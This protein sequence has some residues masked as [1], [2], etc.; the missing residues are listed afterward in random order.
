MLCN[1]GGSARAMALAIVF[2]GDLNLLP[3]ESMVPVKVCVFGGDDRMLEIE[4]DLAER[5]E[6]V[7]FAIGL[8]LIPGL[9]AALD[10]DG[11]CGW[12]DP[13]SRD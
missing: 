3:I 4:G 10:V 12:I 11:G 13:T 1:G 2:G 7:V 8:M 5:N 9:E 6:F